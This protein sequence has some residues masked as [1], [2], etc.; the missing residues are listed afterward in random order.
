MNRAGTA[1]WLPILLLVVAVGCGG[2]GDG[3]PDIVYQPH[4]E[5]ALTRPGGDAVLL[6][7][8]AVIK[9]EDTW[10]LYGTSHPHGFEVWTST[11]LATWSYGGLVWERTPGSWHDRDYGYWAPHVHVSAEGYWLYYTANQRVG[12][13]R[14]DSP[15]GPFVDVL[16]HPLVGNG[17]GGVGD[18]ILT[19]GDSILAD[20]EEKSIDAFLLERADGSLYLYV[21]VNQPPAPPLPPFPVPSIAVLPMADYVTP[22]AARPTVVLDVLPGSWE[23]I[24]REAPWVVE[25]DGVVHLMYSG[26]DYQTTCYAVGIATGTD[27]LGPFTRRTDNPVLHDDPAVGFWGPGHHAVVEGAHDDL[28]I[29]YHTKVSGSRGV[30]R[31]VRYAPVSFDDDGNFRFD[32]PP[33]GDSAPGFNS[34]WP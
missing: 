13:A 18:G 9:V 4:V 33:P 32:V 34:C 12:V 14:A 27:P 8:P 30:E 31:R 6:A 26:N 28:L 22:A 15:L 16:D 5:L 24:V 3:G 2:S 23:S 10:Y 21:L 25:N 7:D 17:Y 20:L 1:R 19:G 29:F 11:D